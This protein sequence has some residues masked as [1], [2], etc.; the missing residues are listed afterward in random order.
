MGRALRARLRKRG[1]HLHV[2]TRGNEVRDA[3]R[4][5]IYGGGIENTDLLRR[6]VPKCAAVVHL[7]SATTP[8]LSGQAPSLEASLN[9]GPTLGLIEILQQHPQVRVIYVSSGGTV[10]GNPGHDL[11]PE[12]AEIKPLSFYGAGKIAVEIFLR[13]LEQ[14]AGN[15]VAILRPSNL[16]GPGQPLYRGFGVIRTMLQHLHDGSVMTIWGDGSVVRDFIYIDDMISAVESVL[17][18]PN[19]TGTFNVG[20]GIGNSLNDL[21][22]TI[23]MVCGSRLQIQYDSSRSIDV[24]RVV[25]DITKIKSKYDWTPAMSLSEGVARTWKWLCA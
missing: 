25:L 10:Y 24:Q 17:A 2:V 4:D 7:A 21:I 19:A 22:R 18:D 3:N 8:G 15:P 12:I 11:V 16:Y 6:L 5:T 14:N 20:S 9:M 13:C 1:F 23:E